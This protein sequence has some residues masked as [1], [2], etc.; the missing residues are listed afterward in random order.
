VEH[1]REKNAH[2]SGCNDQ[3]RLLEAGCN[4]E[5]FDRVVVVR[6]MALVA[7]RVEERVAALDVLRGF[8]L[9][10]VLVVNLHLW[11]R[12]TPA[13]YQLALHP[14]PSA[15]DCATDHAL[16]VFFSLK[17]I[18]LFSL[19]FGAGF[20]M[21]RERALARREAFA[22]FALRR[23][24]MLACFGGLHILLLWMGDILVVYA[25]LGLPL[26]ALLRRRTRTL[27]ICV[28]ALMTLPLLATSIE[29]AISPRILQAPSLDALAQTL[30][31]VEQSVE[32]YAHGSW[33]EILRYRLQEYGALL[34]LLARLSVLVLAAFLLGV[35]GDRYQCFTR[36]HARRCQLQVLAVS[37]VSMGVAVGVM[38]LLCAREPTLGR[39]VLTELVGALQPP[40]ALLQAIGYAAALLLLLER[41]R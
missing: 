14:W 9:F 34:P 35:L 3:Q 22:P 1:R 40:A 11:F 6:M 21:Q 32:V 20:A 30:H 29:L 19:L 13:R 4:S 36:A 39:S 5:H 18:S 12:S 33:V 28:C 41:P 25:V 16:E 23:L 27:L 37:G 2:D 24:G 7:T 26:L 17:F 15:L 10:G 31:S 8:A 38:A